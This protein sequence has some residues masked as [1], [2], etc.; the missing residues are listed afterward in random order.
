MCYILCDVDIVYHRGIYCSAVLCCVHQER[1]TK[2]GVP[3]VHLLVA[4]GFRARAVTA[5]GLPIPDEEEGEGGAEERKGE[6]REGR[7]GGGGGGERG[8]GRSLEVDVDTLTREVS[9]ASEA[10]G[11]HATG[12]LTLLLVMSEPL[13]E[14]AAGREAWKVSCS[15]H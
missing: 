5:L 3:A 14:T 11:T 6:G 12:R 13:T 9:R 8:E 10:E 7:E 1:L 4:V 15:P 2:L